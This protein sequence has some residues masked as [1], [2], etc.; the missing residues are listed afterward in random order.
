MDASVIIP[1][2]NCEKTIEHTLASIF[3]QTIKPKEVIIIDDGSTDNTKKV[4]LETSKKYKLNVK[5]FWQK[6]AGPAKARNEGAKKATA[7][8]IVFTDSDCIP[9]VNWLSEMI[10]PFEKNNV[11]GVQ[12][13]YKSKQKELISRFGQIEIEERYEKMKSSKEI[14]WIGSYSAAFRRKEFLSL[15]GYDESFPIASGEDPEFSFRLA[16]NGGKLIFNQNA[17][18]YHVHPNKLMKYLN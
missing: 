12:G 16:K 5:Y 3:E 11:S 7:E 15:G 2:Y 13:A 9:K 10:K 4:V 17:V 1:C 8:I 18:V 14:D 6:N